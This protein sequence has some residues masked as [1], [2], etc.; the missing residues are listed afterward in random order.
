M[1]AVNRITQT[2]LGLADRG[3]I[4]TYSNRPSFLGTTS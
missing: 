1:K 2:R 4:R 3:D